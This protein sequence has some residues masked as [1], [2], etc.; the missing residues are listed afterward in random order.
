MQK[1]HRLVREVYAAK[2]DM[3]KADRL[4]RDYI[5]FIRSEPAKFPTRFCTDQDDEYSIA[6][7]AFPVAF[8][9]YSRDGAASRT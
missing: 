9:G 8:L 3:E 1:E 5:P 2:T 6:L 7:I 4:I